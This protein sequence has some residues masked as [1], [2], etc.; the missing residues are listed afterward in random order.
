MEIAKITSPSM[1][2]L[3]QAQDAFAGFAEE[4]N[5]KTDEDIVA[6]VKEIRAERE[7]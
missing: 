1:L 6:L 3:H 7:C 5:L 4:N 2:A